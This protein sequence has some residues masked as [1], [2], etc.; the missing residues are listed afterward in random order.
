MVDVKK[1]PPSILLD[2]LAEEFKKDSRISVPEWA[3]YLKAGTHREK[4]WENPDWYYRRLASTLRKV[5][6]LGP[7]GISRLS[8]EYGGKV[9][10]GSKRYHPSK[11]SRFIVR[12]IL[13]ELEKLGYVKKDKKGRSLSPTGVSLLDRTSRE[14]LKEVS[15]ENPA[16]QK[17]L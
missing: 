15:K 14:V 10:M 11:G 16:L 6:V 5:Y 7:I 12:E 9:D 13:Q 3:S 2:R 4:G 1:V 17:Y 8:E